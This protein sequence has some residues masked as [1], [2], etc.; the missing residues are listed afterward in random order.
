[1]NNDDRYPE[2][3]TDLAAKAAEVLV[4]DGGLARPKA[5]KLARRL[6]EMVGMDWAGQQIYISRGVAI[7]DR[8]REIH[9]AFDG[10]NHARLAM[11]YGLTE[12]QIYNIIARIR[13]DDFNKKQLSLFPDE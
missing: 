12:R 7:S 5:E 1:M 9:A 2:I 8:D 6:V 13:R 4:H 11:R 10:S 3:L